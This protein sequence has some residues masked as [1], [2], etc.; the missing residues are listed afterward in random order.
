MGKSHTVSRRDFTVKSALAVLAGTTITIT[1]C[2]SDSPTAPTNGPGPSGETGTI[3]SNLWVANYY[4][5][6]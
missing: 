2:D 6:P 1:A 4:S 3:S 5:A